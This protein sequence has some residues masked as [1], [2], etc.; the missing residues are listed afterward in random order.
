MEHSLKDNSEFTIIGLPPHIAHIYPT[1]QNIQLTYTKHIAYI[2]T[3]YSLHIPCIYLAYSFPIPCLYLPTILYFPKG[4][5]VHF[6]YNFEF[7]VLK[8]IGTHGLRK[9]LKN[10]LKMK[11]FLLFFIFERDFINDIHVLARFL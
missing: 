9:Y 11:F 5:K 7:C 10:T 6:F 2:Y 1:I 3:T 8:T 4:K